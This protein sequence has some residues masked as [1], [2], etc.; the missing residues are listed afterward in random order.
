MEPIV[1]LITYEPATGPIEILKAFRSQRRAN[2]YLTIMRQAPSEAH[3]A[4]AYQLR[5]VPLN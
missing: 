1:Y 3:R 2:E 4:D 5:Q